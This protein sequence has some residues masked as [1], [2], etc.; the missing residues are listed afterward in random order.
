MTLTH[1]RLVERRGRRP[2]LGHLNRGRARAVGG[3]RR[4]DQ[5]GDLRGATSTSMTKG[6]VVKVKTASPLTRSLST[7]SRAT[8][9]V[10][11]R[12]CS[13]CVRSLAFPR[14]CRTPPQSVRFRRTCRHG[15]RATNLRTAKPMP[16]CV[17]RCSAGDKLPRT[18][19]GAQ[20]RS[21]R[22]APTLRPPSDK[23]PFDEPNSM[24]PTR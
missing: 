13:D 16:I 5:T 2:R 7:T 6:G 1:Q 12:L 3:T 4:T 24:S 8:P 20:V 11:T 14:S 23:R 9:T 15:C 19:V 17:T 18:E 22:A 21:E 10:W